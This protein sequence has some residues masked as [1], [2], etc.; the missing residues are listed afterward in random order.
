M[1]ND[2]MKQEYKDNKQRLAICFSQWRKKKKSEHKEKK[3]MPDF[4]NR[5]YPFSEFRVE[6]HDD[7]PL[8][9]I[10][11]VAKFNSLSRDLGGFVERIA[12]GTFAETIQKDDIRSLWNHEAK[13]VLGRTKAGTLMLEEDDKGLKMDNVAP[14]TQWARDLA[15]SVER[16][17]VTEMS[18]GFRTLQDSWNE[19]GK[20]PVRTLE[21]VELKD[22]SIVTFPAYKTTKVQTRE[23]MQREGIDIDA[24][25]RVL[26]KKEHGLEISEDDRIEIDA[27]I[28][29]LKN[30]LPE[31]AETGRET[32]APQ[33]PRLKLKKLDLD[34]R[35]K[36]QEVK[37]HE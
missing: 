25:S 15:V 33:T 36:T 8:R 14:D 24:I 18:F 11:Y 13:Y 6:R 37:K 27:A 26:V 10:G 21:K 5:S 19:E 3:A 20:T 1:S 12:P 9:F 32:D 2:T 31:E 16:G 17:D 35:I 22:V 28:D 29:S 23:L 4:E 7:E 34:N 30:I